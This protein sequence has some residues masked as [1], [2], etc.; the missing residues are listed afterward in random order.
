VA[1]LENGL[2][3]VD[4]EEIYPDVDIR[5]DSSL[6]QVNSSKVIVRILN[7][8]EEATEIWDLE[9]TATKWIEEF[10]VHKVYYHSLDSNVSV[11]SRKE[12]PRNT[13]R[14]ITCQRVIKKLFWKSM[15]DFHDTFYLEVDKL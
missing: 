14:Q 12:C 9:V 4:K 11:L 3:I 13:L 10:C 8:T 1:D 15:R 2:R 6:P 5:V 7:F